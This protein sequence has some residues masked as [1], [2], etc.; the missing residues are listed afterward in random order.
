MGLLDKGKK[1]L[2]GAIQGGGITNPVSAPKAQVAARMGKVRRVLA[3]ANVEAPG[4]DRAGAALDRL[5]SFSGSLTDDIG[6]T[7]SKVNAA[8]DLM[9]EYAGI[10]PDDVAACLNSNKAL[11]ALG[12]AGQQA[13]SKVENAVSA[14]YD[15]VSEWL[16][17]GWDA[18]SDSAL[19]NW[20]QEKLNGSG[21]GYLSELMGDALA[22]LS[23]AGEWVEGL[24]DDCQE[25]LAQMEKTL[26]DYVATL[27]LE[28]FMSH[29]CYKAVVNNV[30]APGVRESLDRIEEIDRLT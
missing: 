4:L 26:K 1:E 18:L 9:N 28:R 10:V 7:L 15:A 11:D 29:P 25:A 21:G 24:V 27:Q 20:V 30:S 2:F 3:L 17:A 6:A 16:G 5:D 14:G 23:A 22:A 19:V 8:S 13:V 12:E